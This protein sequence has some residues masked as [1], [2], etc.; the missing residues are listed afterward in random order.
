MKNSYYLLFCFA[1][2]LT[3][4]LTLHSQPHKYIPFPDSAFIW[5]VWSYDSFNNKESNYQYF[6]NGDDTIIKGEEYFIVYRS[7]FADL[8]ITG[9]QR[10]IRN[11]TLNKKV[12][13]FP[14]SNDTTESILYDFSLK[15]GDT[16]KEE[17]WGGGGMLLYAGG[18]VVTKI[19]S[20]WLDGGW[21]HAWIFDKNHIAPMIEGIG[22]M[23]GP[24]E[25]PFVFEYEYW[26]E[27]AIKDGKSFYPNSSDSCELATLIA[28]NENYQKKLTI[29]PNP[30]SDILT[31]ELQS[32]K[33]LVREILFF[34]LY[35]RLVPPVNIVV[36]EKRRKCNMTGL[37]SGIYTL[38]VIY[39]SGGIETFKI[40]KL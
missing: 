10:Y 34:D 8:P 15:V 36:E 20:I 28:E 27:C 6:T 25:V 5:R 35:G 9:S 22:G 7:R 12:Y 1:L 29:F 16:T 3:Q 33:Q 4:T 23:R 30:V 38:K 39:N 32:D 17:I 14:G 24:F 13:I 2:A 31:I 37:S 40:I 11:D 18:L 26:L 21:H 19:D